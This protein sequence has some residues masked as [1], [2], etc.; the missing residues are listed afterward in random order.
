MCRKVSLRTVIRP[1]LVTA[2]VFLLCAAP[3]IAVLSKKY[4]RLTF[5][6]SATINHAIV[7]PGHVAGHPEVFMAPDHN[8]IFV[9]E[10]D[11]ERYPYQYWSP[12]ESVGNMTHQVKLSI[13]NFGAQAGYLAD[14][15]W[16]HLGLAWLVLGFLTRLPWHE[17]WKLQRWRWGI[18]RERLP[19]ARYTFP[20]TPARAR[21]YFPCMPFLFAAAAGMAGW[22]AACYGDGKRWQRN[23]AL[24]VVTGSF[25]L[26]NVIE[27]GSSLMQRGTD[28]PPWLVLARYLREHELNGGIAGKNG[29]FVALISERPFF[30]GTPNASPDGYIASGAKTI[31]VDRFSHIRKDLD[32]DRRFKGLNGVLYPSEEAARSCELKAYRVVAGP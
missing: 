9:D 32:Q 6:T 30:G 5:S 22:L 21:F 24:L 15:D 13:N 25:L 4:G 14:F 28:V 18:I 23:L 12:L 20:C 17:D 10:A 7:G 27:G 1:V 8:R 31:I 26:P 3:W 16:L 11:I 2:L 19:C 29:E